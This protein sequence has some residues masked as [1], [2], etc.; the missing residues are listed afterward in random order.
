MNPAADLARKL[1][2]RSPSLAASAFA[3]VAALAVFAVLLVVD[4]R[5]VNGQLAWVKPMKFAASG[6]IYTATMAW[7][8][9][10][11]DGRRRAKQVVGWVT[12]GVLVIEFVLIA[13]QAARGV[14][15]HFNVGTRFDQVVFAIMGSL[16]GVA[17]LTG[18][19]VPVLLQRQRF[20]D[21]ALGSALRMGVVVSMLGAA[22]GGLMTQP[23]RAQVA[24]IQRGERPQRVGAHSVGVPD[25][26][27]G[28][29]GVGWSTQGGD[30]R[31]AHFAGLHAL[32]LLP[33]AGLLIR[34]RAARRGL[35]GMAQRRLVRI[36]GG[37]YLGLIGV[38]VVQALRAEPLVAPS[39]FTLSL[40]AGLAALTAVAWAIASRPAGAVASTV[41]VPAYPVKSLRAA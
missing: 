11:V 6:A 8:L 27:A 36:A 20:A 30:L 16:V 40:L 33:L 26:G 5:V 39:A 22:T 10:H 35:D 37:A 14:P 1:W 2:K 9:G 38:L 34:R 23:T 31:V 3:H 18:W 17:W 28:L 15:S 29:P 12:G 24:T 25:G 21:P 41:A 13:L 4:Q 32:Q 7:V 19:V